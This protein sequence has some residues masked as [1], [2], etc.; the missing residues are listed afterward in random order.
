MTKKETNR[1][2]IQNHAIYLSENFK[3][4]IL[5]WAT[6]VG[7]SLAAIK[8]IANDIEKGENRGEWNLWY[9]VVAER[10]HIKNWEDEFKKHGHQRLLD[11]GFVRIFCYQSLHKHKNT[12]AN[13]V[14]DEAHSVTDLRLDILKQV[15]GDKVVSL[16]ATLEPDRLNQLVELE[17]NIYQ[18]TIT[19][20]QA[21]KGEI[22]PSPLIVK[23]EHRLS[24]FL[25]EKYD[26]YT[27]LI[28]GKQKEIDELGDVMKIRD[29]HDEAEIAARVTLLN[30]EQ[31]KLRMQRKALLANSKSSTAEK[32]QDQITIWG[33]KFIV[34]TGTMAQCKRLGN[35]M[36][37][38]GDINSEI[39]QKKIKEKIEQFNNDVLKALVTNK[40][41][42]QGT[43]L[44]GI[45]M[46]I[47]CQ[48]D[49]KELSFI[50]MMGRVFR[51]DDPVLFVFV[52]KDTVDEIY[53]EA[54]TKDLDPKYIVPYEEYI[55]DRHAKV[56]QK[57]QS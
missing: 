40:M 39:P 33:K 15:K 26:T 11:L 44:D 6:G 31:L 30:S 24:P 38:Y 27:T 51:S 29:V 56:Q 18:Y 22:L 48:L 4:V 49:S 43:N 45:E 23:V 10:Q 42:R 57:S 20:G 55:K 1:N 54:C 21:I 12:K 16:S 3:Q 7:K 35:R 52:T 46:G 13:L 28:K 9:I 25:K 53:W 37:Y 36:L 47:I 41:L 8:I 14:L 32:L 2:N 5:S 19:T 34:F 17:P 50:Q